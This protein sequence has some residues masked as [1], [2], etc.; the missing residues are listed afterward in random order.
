MIEKGSFFLIKSLLKLVCVL[1]GVRRGLH[2]I[3]GK[4]T[5]FLF[6]K[7]FFETDSWPVSGDKGGFISCNHSGEVSLQAIKQNKKVFY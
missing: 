2:L 6:K 5:S 4:E 1:T 3:C 7:Y